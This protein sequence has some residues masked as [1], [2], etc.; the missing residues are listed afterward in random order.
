[1]TMADEVVGAGAQAQLAVPRESEKKILVLSKN[2]TSI[3]SEGRWDQ[4]I[5]ELNDL[6]WDVVLDQEPGEKRKRIPSKLMLDIWF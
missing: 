6:E 3:Q 5:G 1:M 4:L 2:L